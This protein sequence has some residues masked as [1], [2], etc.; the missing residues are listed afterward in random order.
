[1]AE[2]EAAVPSQI[3][4]DR[5]LDG[6]IAEPGTNQTT[7]QASTEK[8]T[9]TTA[10]AS[11]KGTSL[12][13]DGE[14]SGASKEKAPDATA[15]ESGKKAASEGAPET[16]SDYKVPE[17]YTLD[18]EVK[19]KADTLFKGLNLNQEQAQSLV[20]FYTAET[21]EAFEA[22]FNAWTDLTQQWR[23]EASNHPDLKGKMG[24]GGEVSTRVAKALAS[25][26]NADLVTDFRK[27][28][29]ITGAGN[30]QAFIRVLDHFAKLATEG[31]PVRGQGPSEHGQSDSGRATN[32]T[33]AQAMYPHLPSNSR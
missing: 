24:P 28:M 26:G 15:Q 14:D 17:G 21:K 32:R 12:L 9:D 22:P 5:T 16:Y 6:T 11:P 30:H 1:M 4:V 18:P 27:L 2:A 10:T 19:T 3:G 23:D 8:T 25:I 7:T 20:D 33:A 29:D 31:T 13:N